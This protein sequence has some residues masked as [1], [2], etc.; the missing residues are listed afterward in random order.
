VY[1]CFKKDDV[2][3]EVPY[4]VK[5][6]REDDEEK[7]MAHLKEFQMTS[8]LNHKNIVKSIEIYDNSLT[9]EIHQIMEYIEG[10]EVLD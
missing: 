9:G 8:N 6:S 3:K 1:K 2:L 4:A 5:I 7:K 10:S